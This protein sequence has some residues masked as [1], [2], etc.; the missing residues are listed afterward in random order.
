MEAAEDVDLVLVLM[1]IGNTQP[2][3]TV[4]Y[5]AIRSAHADKALVFLT[6][7]TYVHSGSPC[8]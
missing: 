6:G 2:E 5:D 7:H 1:H 4:V 8:T 3:Y